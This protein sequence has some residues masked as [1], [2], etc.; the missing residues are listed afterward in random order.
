MYLKQSKSEQFKQIE[1]KT[2]KIYEK[3][4]NEILQ[5]CIRIYKRSNKKTNKKISKRYRKY[6][7]CE[8]FQMHKNGRKFSNEKAMCFE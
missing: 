3:C 1:Y 4:T 5:Q 8:S 7:E 6:V 2:R